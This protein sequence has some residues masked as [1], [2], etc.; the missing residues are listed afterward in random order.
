MMA[1]SM[2]KIF[3]V[4]AAA[5]AGLGA[6]AQP[7]SPTEMG[8]F[9]GRRDMAVMRL[10]TNLGSFRSIDG[11]GRLEFSFSGTV[12]LANVDGRVTQTSNLRKEYELKDAKGKVIRQVFSGTGRFVIEG[13]WRAVQWFGSDMRAVWW[14]KGF[15]RI[16]GEFDRNLRTGD[17]W[18]DNPAQKQAWPSTSLLTLTLPPP[19]FG[20]NP[21]ANPQMRR[22]T[23]N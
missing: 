21:N 6:M 14:G 18:Y 23:G 20:A 2:Y 7:A 8:S 11:E 9:A 4:S 12:L 19:A 1:Q 10:N 13:K 17:Y 22:R 3:L 5:L 16:T 15:M